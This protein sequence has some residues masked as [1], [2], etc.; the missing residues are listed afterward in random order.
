[1]L[2]RRLSTHISRKTASFL[3]ISNPYK[4]FAENRPC[5]STEIYSVL[6][7]L[8]QLEKSTSLS[9]IDA[10]KCMTVIRLQETQ[11]LR[12]SHCPSWSLWDFRGIN[13]K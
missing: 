5:R 12:E 13:V 8:P 1:M 6:S 2:K 9:L 11:E 7:R 10:F 4:N 3:H